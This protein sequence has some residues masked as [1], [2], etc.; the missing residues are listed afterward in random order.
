M[1]LLEREQENVERALD[2]LRQGLRGAEQRL[3]E[4]QGFN[5]SAWA[6]H[7]SE[8]CAESLRTNEQRLESS[9]KSIER[10]I[11]LL[12]TYRAGLFSIT[13]SREKYLR[14]QIQDSEAKIQLHRDLIEIG[15]REL[16][17]VEL[18]RKLLA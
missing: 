17:E 16:A 8:L 10:R 14:K 18:V 7:G 11:V 5:K 9:I 15:N 1:A 6:T 13:P 12:I 3:V 2:L 4:E